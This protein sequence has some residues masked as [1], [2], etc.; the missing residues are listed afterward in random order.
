MGTHNNHNNYNDVSM[1]ILPRVIKQ[2]Y[3]IKSSLDGK[4]D[5]LIKVSFLEIYNE[6]IYDLLDY[7]RKNSGNANNN[8]QSTGIGIREEK[9]GQISVYG[10][11]EK[12]ADSKEEMMDCL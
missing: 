7:Y 12:Q 6:E 11:V 5:V 4:V 10:C 2:I 3:D 8:A 1:G 9:D